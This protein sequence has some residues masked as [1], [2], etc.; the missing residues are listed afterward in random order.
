M[1]AGASATIL[2]PSLV[3]PAVGRQKARTLH[4]T[5]Y[6]QPAAGPSLSIFIFDIKT[7]LFVC[8]VFCSYFF[9]DGT[10]GQ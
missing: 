3:V 4:D 7:I 1:E 8:L 9:H 5:C 10:A 6:T 2:I